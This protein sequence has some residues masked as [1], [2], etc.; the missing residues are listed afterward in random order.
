MVVGDLNRDDKADLA[1]TNYGDNTVSVLLGNGD[2]TFHAHVDYPT[3]NHPGSVAI[4]DFN[5]DGQPDLAVANAGD[6]Q[7][8]RT[9]RVLLGDGE[10]RFQVHVSYPTDDYI[11]S[12]AVGDFNGDGK[13]D[14]VMANSEV[15]S[16]SLLLGNGDGSFQM[17][18][19][20]A[21][22][23]GPSLIVGDFNHD[24]KL[25]LAVANYED[26]TMSVL[27]GDGNGTFQPH[28]DYPTGHSP[29]SLAVGDFNGDGKLDLAVAN[30]SGNSVS[31]LLGSGD[32]TFHAH[33]DYPTGNHPGSVAVGDFNADGKPDLALVNVYQSDRTVS[34]LMGNADGTFQASM[35]YASGQVLDAA[36]PADF[37]MDGA[38]D[39]AV[40]T[41]F[42]SATILLNIRG[43]KA[44][45]RSSANPSTF[46][47][48]VNLTATIQASLNAAVSGTPTG[49][50]TFVDGTE[51]L[52][53]QNLNEN[54]VATISIDNLI[55]GTND[56]TAV[57]RGDVNFN[58]ATSAVLTQV[59][60]DFAVSATPGSAAIKAGSSAVF[61][62]TATGMYG[63]DG[64][65][66]LSCS[67]SPI[68]ALA[69]TCVLN[70][71]SVM[72][73]ASGTATSQLSVAT[74][75]PTASLV[76][77]TFRHGLSP[78]YM[79][80]LPICGLAVMGTG[81]TCDRKERTLF[82]ELSSFLYSS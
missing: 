27:L 9:V 26:D 61:T 19:D 73:T 55:A 32:G 82:L 40:S 38:L 34:V 60:R 72:P 18:V 3:G 45:L 41:P 68:P 44:E 28:V 6:Y 69:P 71:S 42:N 14:L 80:W 46:G 81:L 10:G 66:S 17:H 25:D 51:T 47:Q 57:Y 36:T 62:L 21:T 33:V 30:T 63:F 53:S 15:N 67:V 78:A 77:P 54:G 43:T 59:V 64:P 39:L 75:G 31:V 12:I 50:I 58:P 29:S 70:P 5:G 52:G 2:G 24:G 49:T 56:I 65:V 23:N 11:S 22:G 37:N 76:R 1:I 48:A 74:T 16:V 4:G 79:V 8:P 7:N 35:N 13:P 20:Y